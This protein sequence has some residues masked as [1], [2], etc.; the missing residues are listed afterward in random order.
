ML[1]NSNLVIKLTTIIILPAIAL[2]ALT[3]VAS[4]KM[5]QI[6]IQMNKALYQEAYISTVSIINADRDLYQASKSEVIL[7]MGED[8]L[9]NVEK[10]AELESFKI[11]K[12]QAFNGI[13]KAYENIASNTNLTNEYLDIVTGK[14][15]SQLYEEFNDSY[16]Q[17]DEMV[18]DPTLLTKNEF[19][20]SELMFEATRKPINVM[21]EVLKSYCEQT[22]ISEIKS[23][24]NARNIFIIVALLMLLTTIFI[25]VNIGKHISFM[26]KLVK[27]NITNLAEGDL[28]ATDNQQVVRYKD[29]FGELARN[30]KQVTV[31]LKTIVQ[32]I[33]EETTSIDQAIYQ[34][35][36]NVQHTASI[37]EEIA[38]TVSQIAGGAMNQAEDAESASN[39]INE[40]ADIISSNAELA[41]ALVEQSSKISSLTEDGLV[42]VESLAIKTE[43]S[44]K[45]MADL[46][47]VAEI[48][49]L[50]TNNIGEASKMISDIANQTN[51]LALNAAIEAAR[52][53]DAGKGF[54]V[55]A[56][57]IRKLAEQS[58]KSTAQIDQML[59][60]LKRNSDRSIETSRQLQEVV[61]VQGESVMET[62]TKYKEIAEAIS[63]SLELSEQINLYGKDMEEKREKVMA[64]IEG[65][66]SIAEENAA[67]TQESSASIQEVSSTMQEL[68]ENSNG[69]KERS[70]R[71]IQLIQQ[72]KL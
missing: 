24:E 2:L 7:V 45:S 19:I 35:G 51:L 46:S 6:P 16:K 18:K 54:A 8:E 13:Q 42:L 68:N 71:L 17:W 44:K 26:L 15:I 14:S 32:G 49:K 22:A 50:S 69:V 40:L 3:G 64:V 63:M 53:G 21:A 60:D 30:V 56:D 31:S 38:S 5:T 66:A 20:Q 27:N 58:A 33:H 4:Y 48:T 10:I 70:Q 25:S 29:E 41:N 72:F 34:M 59:K 36:N 62:Q 55:V 39:E 28:T 1:K 37:I 43:E 23:S 11:N 67:S 52:A 47:D 65:L 57:E 61:E 12:L 9:T